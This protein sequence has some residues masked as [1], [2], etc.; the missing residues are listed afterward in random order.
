[1]T[2]KQLV[3]RL[4]SIRRFCMESASYLDALP[5][6][7]LERIAAFSYLLQYVYDEIEEMI[8][9]FRSFP[10]KQKAYQTQQAINSLIG[11]CDNYIENVFA[12][13]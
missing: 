10:P 1:M 11:A 5:N 12:T 13:D 6:P 9:D 2:Q 7:T 8:G 3:G 4:N